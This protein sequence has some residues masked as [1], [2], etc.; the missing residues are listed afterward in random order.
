MTL[1]ESFFKIE[2]KEKIQVISGS[3]RR[4]GKHNYIIFPIKIKVKKFYE[5][6]LLGKIVQFDNI[7]Q[8]PTIG[9]FNYLSLQSVRLVLV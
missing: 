8:D 5:K 2:I 9:T 4:E 1:H 7:Y 3:K 6:I